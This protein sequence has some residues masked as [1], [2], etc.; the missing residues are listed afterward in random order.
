MI[1]KYRTLAP[2]LAILMLHSTIAPVALAA[3]SVREAKRAV[4]AKHRMSLERF[5]AQGTVIPTADTSFDTPQFLRSIRL[6][7]SIPADSIKQLRATL[8]NYAKATKSDPSSL[9]MM[10]TIVD[11]ITATSDDE[12]HLK[13]Q[14]LPIQ[15]VRHIRAKRDSVVGIEVEYRLR[16]VLKARTFRAV[17]TELKRGAA[18]LAPPENAAENA[19]IQLGGPSDS[20]PTTR[21]ITCQY[22]TPDA[23]LIEGECATQQEIDDALT[24]LIA[25][26]AE[27]AGAQ[28]TVATSSS[29]YCSSH[30][31]D[32]ATW[33]Q[34]DAASV[35]GPRAEAAAPLYASL[36]N[37]SFDSIDEALGAGH[38]THL[39]VAR[40]C[41]S[42]VWGYVASLGAFGVAAFALGH[43]ATA[44]AVA[45]PVAAVVGIALGGA[46]FAAAAVIGTGIAVYECQHAT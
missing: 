13:I 42:A 46:V 14:S 40:G 1:R 23:V 21:A 24:T 18:M 39:M 17:E 8:L 28:A 34:D 15:I 20:F 35:G 45:A 6:M 29:E 22:Y 10:L 3:D 38:V 2:L 9:S 31:A 26:D 32:C 25:L 43:A 11:A 5:D 4:P 33:E 44:T 37:Y 36:A 27:I 7:R 30:A 16:G 12:F 41:A 19:T